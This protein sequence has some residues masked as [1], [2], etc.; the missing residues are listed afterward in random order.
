[1]YVLS[2]HSLLDMYCLFALRLISVSS[3][4]HPRFL[5]SL[6][7]S[8]FLSAR[9]SPSLSQPL[10]PH[11]PRFCPKPLGKERV[12]STSWGWGAAFLCP[13]LVPSAF[14]E[15]GGGWREL[16]CILMP[17]GLSR[18]QR[19]QQR[20]CHRLRQRRAGG[21][22]GGREGGQVKQAFWQS[23][24]H[25][26]KPQKREAWRGLMWWA[27]AAFFRQ[28]ARIQCHCPHAQLRCRGPWILHAA[29]AFL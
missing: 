20:C 18:P 7:P 17:C 1:M 16:G 2:V 27:T 25:M 28:L 4:P 9:A 10:Q 26:W 29:H 23:Q 21:R 3:F 12:K 15:T 19:A 24:Q 11:F 13:W 22:Q 6:L 5:S 8:S 14:W